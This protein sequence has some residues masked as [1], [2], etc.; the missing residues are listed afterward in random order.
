MASVKSRQMKYFLM[1][2]FIV[3]FASQA[4]A[5]KRGQIL[6]VR[7][8]PQ[9]IQMKG[10]SSEGCSGIVL[11]PHLII[12][13]GHCIELM[14]HGIK[15]LTLSKGTAGT[16]TEV[17]IVS[18]DKN[19]LYVLGFAKHPVLSEIPHDVAYLMTKQD[20]YKNLGI[21]ENLEIAVPER[22]QLSQNLQT[23]NAVAIGLG[24][25]GQG[26]MTGRSQASLKRSVEMVVRYNF[27]S[28]VLMSTAVK[29]GTGL[30]RGDSGGALIVNHAVMGILSAVALQG[31]CQKDG[32]FAYHALLEDS[33]CWLEKAT[34]QSLSP[35][36]FCE[37]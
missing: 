28:H 15:K 29:D 21:T 14:G 13:A 17:D 4:L 34:G 30:C 27:D 22:S 10:W 36:G 8:Y 31:D 32:G 9:I 20:L 18:L 3:V 6:F 23:V 35:S 37:H 11:R 7:D 16:E 12:T 33:V 2:A 26:N 1:S 5:V 19:P 24:E 25:T